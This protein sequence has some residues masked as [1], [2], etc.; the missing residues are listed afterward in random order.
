M[1]RGVSLV[2]V[3]PRDGFQ[4]VV[5]FIPTGEKIRIVQ[6][7]YAAGLRRIE[8]TSFV[9][10]AVPQLADA[11][12]VLAAALALP[13][14]DAQVLVPNQKHTERALAAGARHVAFFL[15][16]SETHNLNNVRRTPG[17]SVGD[18]AK[19]AAMLPQGI[20]FRLNIA[21]AFDCPFGGAVAPKV[22]LDLLAQLVALEPN[23]EIA[24]CDTTGRAVPGNVAA[25]F[26]AAMASFPQ[27]PGW[28]FH[29]HDTYGM[30]A[31]NAFAAWSAG[32]EVI[33]ASAAGLGGCPFAPGATGNV[34]T[35]DLVWMFEGMNV[36]TG[37][38]LPLLLEAGREVAAL[39]GAQTGGRVREAL[40]V[41]KI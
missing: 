41:T 34:A 38:D 9:G 7:L 39:P 18:Y 2:E 19:I 25:L 36:A 23:V 17:E 4:P 31:A 37:V 35:E 29:G 33:D 20:S 10:S 40:R 8:V 14:L 13:G 5:P 11:R 1:M 6:A 21:T 3:A 32:V 15:S 22:V 26:Q 27:V 12:E 30:G 16:A 28:A 24:L